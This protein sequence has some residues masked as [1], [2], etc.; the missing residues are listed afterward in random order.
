MKQAR[1]AK[2]TDAARSPKE[3]LLQGMNP[4]EVARVSGL[5]PEEVSAARAQLEPVIRCSICTG[6]QVAGFRDKQTGEFLEIAL[7]RGERDLQAF[8]TRYG[9]DG[10]IKKIY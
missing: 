1:R 7:L 3:L 6:E 8:R 9:I 5:P 10:P 2:S 4:D